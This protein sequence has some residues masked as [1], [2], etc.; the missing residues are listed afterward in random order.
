MI[1]DEALFWGGGLSSGARCFAYEMA[2]G[3]YARQAVP[4]ASLTAGEMRRFVSFALLTGRMRGFKKGY[5]LERL[6]RD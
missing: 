6:A 5:L 4:N 2:T 3:C 1:G